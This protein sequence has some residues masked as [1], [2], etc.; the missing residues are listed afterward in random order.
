ML[1]TKITTALEAALAAWQQSR[2]GCDLIQAQEEFGRLPLGLQNLILD[3]ATVA[4]R[5]RYSALQCMWRSWHGFEATTWLDELR[6]CGV[7][8]P[9]QLDSRIWDIDPNLAYLAQS[10]LLDPQSCHYGS[11]LWMHNGEVL[12]WQQV[13][14]LFV[15]AGMQLCGGVDTCM[16]A[17]Q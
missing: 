13:S 4:R 12:G 9:S 16:Y 8:R 10:V 14:M 11:R 1:E 7:M 17:C 15:I 5:S 2:S 3:A 6:L